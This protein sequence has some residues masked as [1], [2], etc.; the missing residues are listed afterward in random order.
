[1]KIFSLFFPKKEWHKW[2]PAF[3]LLLVAI[4]ARIVSWRVD[5][6]GGYFDDYWLMTNVEKSFIEYVSGLGAILGLGQ[7]YPS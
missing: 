7:F 3:S 5:L 4:T 6:F 1:M 2:L